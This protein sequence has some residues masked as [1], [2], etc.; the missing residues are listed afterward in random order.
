MTPRRRSGYFYRTHRKISFLLRRGSLFRAGQGLK[1]GTLKDRTISKGA[2]TLIGINSTFLFLLAYILVFFLYNFATALAAYAFD[3]PTIIYY[4]DVAFLIKGVGWSADSVK[5]V[6]SAGPLAALLAGIILV[7]VYNIVA[8]ENGILRLLVLWMFAHAVVFFFGEVMMGSLFGR[9]FGYV[10]MYLYA[11]DT[12]MMVITVLCLI[13]MATLGFRFAR[14]FVVSANIYFNE[15]PTYYI[16][17]FL[18]FQFIVP[19]VAGNIIICLVKLPGISLYEITL[20]LTM[21]FLLI[22]VM[23]EGSR[24][25]D[26]YFDEDPR[27][28]RIYFLLALI[29]VMAMLAFRIV[30]GS[31]LKLFF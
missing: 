23:I 24:L 12:V 11:K 9:G 6:Y 14:L 25:E 26:F 7:I 31:G 17:K 3:I 19:F 15:M 5:V 28:I 2:F 1:E 30:L 4:N 8:E 10:L 16:R 20:N 13:G 27:R 22:P 21:L 29:T 18:A